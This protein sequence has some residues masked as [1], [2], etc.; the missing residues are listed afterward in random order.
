MYN[1][2]KIKYPDRVPIIIEEN[3]I[4]IEA[5]K[6]LVP[7]NLKIS[8]FLALIRKKIKI[9]KFEAIFTFVKE[10]ENN[11]ILMKMNETVQSVYNEYKQ[12]DGLVYL[13][14]KIEN[15]FG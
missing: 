9:N 4:K 8:E 11:Y 3:E 15:T 13:K 1:Y 14:F 5:R 2:L 6:Y 12:E 10:N 7:S